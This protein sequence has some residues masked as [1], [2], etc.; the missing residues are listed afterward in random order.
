[1]SVVAQ[2]I[3]SQGGLPGLP[4]Q[5]YIGVDGVLVTITNADDTGVTYWK[6]ELL[7]VPLGSTISPGILSEGTAPSVTFTPEIGIVGCYRVKLTVRGPTGEN[8]DVRNFAVPTRVHSWI[9]PS[10]LAEANEMNFTGQLRGWMRWV[11]E[12][13]LY[14]DGLILPAGTENR[15]FLTWQQSPPPGRWIVTRDFVGVAP[16]SDSDTLEVK[17]DSSTVYAGRNTAIRG[18]STTGT[19]KAG[20]YAGIFGGSSDSGAGGNAYWSPGGG[21]SPSANGKCRFGGNYEDQSRWSFYADVSI[22]NPAG[23]SYSGGQWWWKANGETELQWHPFATSSVPIGAINQVL[24]S[25]GTAYDWRDNLA[26]PAGVRTVGIATPTADNQRATLT[27]A[28]TG[29]YTGVDAELRG[30]NSTGGGKRGGHAYL[31]PGKGPAGQGQ[32]RFGYKDGAFT[33]FALYPD[34]AYLTSGSN[35]FAPGVRYD[36]GSDG[37]ELQT[38]SLEWFAIGSGLPTGT[39]GQILRN[40]GSGWSPTSDWIMASAVYRYIRTAAPAIDGEELSMGTANSATYGT[41][42]YTLETGNTSQA[43]K[44]AGDVRLRPGYSVG[45]QGRVLF[46]AKNGEEFALYPDPAYLTSGSNDYAPGVRYDEGSDGWELQTKTFEWFP[47]ASGLLPSGTIYQHLEHNGTAWAAV[48]SLT[49]PAG[50]MIDGI[51][52][53]QIAE[54]S[55]GCVLH[56]K[57]GDRTGS[58]GGKDLWLEPGG[59]VTGDSGSVTFGPLDAELDDAYQILAR[60]T[61]GTYRPGYRYNPGLK[62]L[63]GRTEDNTW[64]PFLFDVLIA[65]FPVVQAD[66][67][68]ADGAQLIYSADRMQWESSNPSMST[69]TRITPYDEFDV[70]GVMGDNQIGATNVIGYANPATQRTRIEFPVI[71]GMT[72]GEQGFFTRCPRVGAT[73][74]TGLRGGTDLVLDYKLGSLSIWFRLR[75]A[76]AAERVNLLGYGDNAGGTV[77]GLELTN[78]GLSATMITNH[79]SFSITTIAEDLQSL[80]GVWHLASLNY[81]G[82]FLRLYLDGAYISKVAATGNIQWGAGKKWHINANG[83]GGSGYSF[84]GHFCD[85]RAAAA[86]RPATYYEKMYRLAMMWPDPIEP[87]TEP[88]VGGMTP[89]GLS[90]Y[91][92]G[93]TQ[94]TPVYTP[95]NTYRTDWVRFDAPKNTWIVSGVNS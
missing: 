67:T 73:T 90:V 15:Q 54:S 10:F 17:P 74:C 52:H 30:G 72:L 93:P 25:T 85:A 91:D 18:G 87:M 31:H 32:T 39:L 94:Y 95:I 51:R 1:M 66:E 6:Y 76:I 86:L 9:I 5:S 53:V 7:D 88:I 82:Q 26:L 43:G 58:G 81:D 44:L 75:K 11:N 68:P 19:G 22:S 47:I 46:G 13:L 36:E 4:A 70:L 40:N 37:W 42:H 16:D 78:A 21:A 20:G 79:G 62:R 35:D 63:E 12:I 48:T 77:F 2:M 92:P 45:G 60:K 83:A 8:I 38:K 64:R 41:A 69:S 49:L 57:A 24:Q 80:V 84:I 71:A 55:T 61:D 50:S 14:I 3:L 28:D 23:L 89:E 59:H 65:G 33:E 56:L 34:P 27:G 29:V